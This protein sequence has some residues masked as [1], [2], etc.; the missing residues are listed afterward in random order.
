MRLD[1]VHPHGSI[2]RLHGL[3]AVPRLS[4]SGAK[5]MPWKTYRRRH[6]G[7]ERGGVREGTAPKWAC[8]FLEDSPLTPPQKKWWLSCGLPY[9]PFKASKRGPPKK[10]MTNPKYPERVRASVSSSAFWLLQTLSC[11]G[12]YP[13][14]KFTSSGPNPLFKPGYSHSHL[15]RL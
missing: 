2:R 6:S 10:R 3:S 7:L 12:V 5:A 13:C 1:F 8:L 14:F 4:A 11:L 9:L 15:C